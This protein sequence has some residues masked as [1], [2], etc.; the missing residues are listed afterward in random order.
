M[1]Q[2]SGLNIS[3]AQKNVHECTFFCA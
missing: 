3:Y 2:L 1:R